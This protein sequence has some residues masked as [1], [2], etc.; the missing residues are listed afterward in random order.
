MLPMPAALGSVSLEVL[1]DYREKVGLLLDNCYWSVISFRLQ[2]VEKQANFLGQ[3][4]PVLKA[5]WRRRQ[6]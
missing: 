4:V 5:I 2:G 3:V 1:I 6:L